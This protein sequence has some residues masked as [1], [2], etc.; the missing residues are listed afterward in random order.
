MKGIII[1][2]LSN[3]TTKNTAILYLAIIFNILLGW[4]LTKLNTTY[5]T[6]NDYGKY[7]FF[8]II[9]YYSRSFFSLGFF[10][11]TSRLLALQD[12]E[13]DRKKLYGA[14]VITVLLLNIP[15]I[16]LFYAF[17]FFS[18]SIFKVDIGRICNDF[19]VLAGFI[20]MQSYLMTTLKGSGSIKE[21]SLYTI[22][23]R[24]FYIGILYYFLVVDQ[25]TLYNTI[26]ALFLGIAVASIITLFQIKPVFKLAKQKFTEI[27]NENK[28]YGIHIYFGNI[29]HETLFHSD[30]LLISYFLD[31]ENMAYYGLAFMLTYP[32]S[33]FSTSLAT[34][35][36]TKF[37]SQTMINQKVLR[38]NLIF[39]FVSVLL[40]IFF[41]EPIIHY[42]FSDDYLPAVKLMLPLALAFGFSGMSKPFTLFLMARGEGRIVRNISIAVP[43][44]NVFL[45]FVII[46]FY[47]ILGAA[48]VAF[49][50]YGLDFMLY[51]FYYH[52]HIKKF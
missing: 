28:R 44:I 48:W 39:V 8:I 16:L 49:F 20:L 17:S 9:I 15:Y 41:R 22:A 21:L 13:L 31:S 18:D 1:N 26:L 19:A 23:P 7:A 6:I 4:V 33:H 29:L 36:Y 30:K 38:Y 5:L 52:Q 25:F 12:S 27:I 37:A 34:T 3:K 40:F 10:E 35:L 14:S 51:Y 47:G 45:N 11:S 2:F 42:L 32:L 46:P 43:V 24:F 50:M